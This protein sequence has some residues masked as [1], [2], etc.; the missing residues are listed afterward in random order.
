MLGNL[1]PTSYSVSLEKL[2]AVAVRAWSPSPRRR[3][4]F[5]CPY[6]CMEGIIVSKCDGSCSLAKGGPTRSRADVDDFLGIVPNRRIKELPV[7]VFF[8]NRATQG[9]FSVYSGSEATYSE[10]QHHG[11]FHVFSI[12]FLVVVGDGISAVLVPVISSA[13]LV[14]VLPHTRPHFSRRKAQ[15]IPVGYRVELV[16][17]GRPLGRLY[18]CSGGLPRGDGGHGGGGLGMVV[19]RRL[20]V[21]R[22]QIY[23]TQKPTTAIPASKRAWGWRHGAE[24]R[25]I[26]IRPQ[27]ET[28][29]GAGTGKTGV[30]NWKC[31]I[32]GD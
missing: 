28:G 29:T 17:V 21:D 12:L 22:C 20:Q 1:S 32:P 14:D 9:L 27:G 30:A 26:P 16:G 31:W 18:R 10:L 2:H 23:T 8:V 24:V 15:R 11:M 13:V 6:S 4:T 25:Q 5:D 7:L 19:R 3:R